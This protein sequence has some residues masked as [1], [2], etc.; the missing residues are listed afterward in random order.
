MQLYFGDF[1]SNLLGLVVILTFLMLVFYYPIT[2]KVIGL[3]L[4]GLGLIFS[5]T[6]IGEIIGVPAV[7]LGL[8]LALWPSPK[9]EEE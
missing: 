4:T 5:F 6:T 1:I 2:R 9:R 7:V 3:I 8:T